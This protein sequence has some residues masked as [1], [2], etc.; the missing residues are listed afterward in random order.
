MKKIYS[1]L[2][3]LVLSLTLMAQQRAQDQRSEEFLMRLKAH[4]EESSRQGSKINTPPDFGKNKNLLLHE[5]F[6]GEV[7]PPEGWSALPDVTFVPVENGFFPEWYYIDA[8][9]TTPPGGGNISL[10]S[11]LGFEG[12]MFSP[13][14]KWLI[15]PE[16]TVNMPSTL[17]FWARLGI[18][19]LDNL[20]ILVST[21][22]ADP[23]DFTVQLADIHY[24][25]LQ[26]WTMHT[27]DLLSF[28]GQTI[29][30]A[31]RNHVE[32]NMLHGGGLFLDMISVVEHVGPPE[33]ALRPQPQDDAQLLNPFSP[34]FSWDAVGATSYDIYIGQN[35]PEHPTLNLQ[36]RVFY[37]ELLPNK[38]YQWKVVPKSTMGEAQNCPIW[39]FTTGDVVEEYL[40]V[41]DE[42]VY[43]SEGRFFD[44]GG[45]ERPYNLNDQSVRTFFPANQ[46]EKLRFNFTD[47]HTE[48]NIDKLYVYDGPDINSPQIPGSPFN[49]A[50]APVF[51][52]DLV[53]T[54]PQGAI[55]F[56]MDADEYIAKDGWQA[57]FS[58]F[59]PLQQN[60]VIKH[61]SADRITTTTQECNFR[62]LVQNEGLQA[63]N[64]F[65]IILK[66][67]EGQ[68]I[69][70]FNNLGIISA[71]EYKEVSVQKIFQQAA[72]YEIFAVA[73]INGQECIQ[74]NALSIPVKILENHSISSVGQPDEPAKYPIVLHWEK[75]VF[76]TIYMA[77]EID[78]T[79]YIN[80]LGFIKDFAADYNIN[81]KIWL[82]KP[83]TLLTHLTL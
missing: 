12:P 9:K 1:I 41:N 3:M 83:R 7:F 31:F 57:S 6:E 80:A 23:E 60:I 79:G 82:G 68:V 15:T 30:I 37:P 38:S 78:R 81:I 49:D 51:L 69:H 34:R 39:T 44:S 42:D 35:L 59:V 2:I 27:Y 5:S 50:V 72:E 4:H 70:E 63:V 20:E 48:I 62:L 25:N 77:E 22:G 29:R 43:S 32:N 54:N 14:E 17:V 19:Y 21:S 66:D 76:Q 45:I 47:F 26:D 13:G 67:G 28:M 18:N 74:E 65:G 56:R 73:V 64:D 33:C 52:K 10:W 24:N 16:I 58:A 46:D 53:A 75:S 55:T 71:G 61:I 40:L 8:E 36:D 11:F